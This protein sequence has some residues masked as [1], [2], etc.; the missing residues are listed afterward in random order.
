MSNNISKKLAHLLIISSFVLFASASFLSLGESKVNNEKKLIASG[1]SITKKPDATL[2]ELN[3]DSKSTEEVK[4]ENN[5]TKSTTTSDSKSNNNSSTGNAGTITSNNNSGGGSGG[6]TPNPTTNPATPTPTY[7]DTNNNLRVNIENQYNVNV[8]YGSETNGYT[9]GGMSTIPLTDVNS[10]TRALNSLNFCLSKYPSNLFNEIH[11]AYPL[12]IYLINKY[13]VDN[14]T[15]VTDS[16]NRTVNLSIATAYS[17][18]VSFHH[19]I[20]HYI[21]HYMFS[22]GASFNT[23]NSLNPGGFSYG[24][25]NANLAYSRTLSPDSYFVNE[26]AMYSDAEDRA[27]TFE[28]MTSGSKASCLNSG[29]PVNLKAKYMAQT[30]EY[31]IN[32]VSPSVTEYWERFL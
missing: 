26:Y 1:V 9:V 10:I 14:V 17:F 3:D 6:T 28:Y 23:W 7:V 29:K 25:V 19:E 30:M 4:Q 12:N 31:Y 15:G 18:D 21:E 16:T 27:S 32:S 11:A 22:R 8:I 13:S 5:D 20:Y 24:N 2:E